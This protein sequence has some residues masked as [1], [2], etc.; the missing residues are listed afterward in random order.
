MAKSEN[1]MSNERYRNAL[2]RKLMEFFQ[3]KEGGEEWV[4]QVASNAFGFPF[5]NDVGSE[6]IVK[7]TVSIPQERENRMTLT[8]KPKITRLPFPKSWKERKRRK[9]QKTR[10]LRGTRRKGKIWKS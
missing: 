6:E 5:V 9:R 1:N 2:I 7:I 8:E 4:L 10:K 3:S